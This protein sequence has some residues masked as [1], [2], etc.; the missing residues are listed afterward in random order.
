M[1]YKELMGYKNGIVFTVLFLFVAVNL[2]PQDELLQRGTIPAELL[3]PRREEALRFPIDVVIGPLGQGSAPREAYDIAITA[4]AALLAG[5]A[6]AAVFSSVNKVF[7]EGCMS[8]LNVINPRSYRIGG[9]REEPD[10]SVSFLVRFSGREQGITGELFI[11]QELV[12]QQTPAPVPQ[13]AA[14]PPDED[15]ESAGNDEAEENETSETETETSENENENETTTEAETIPEPP[16][17][18][19]ERRR[20]IFEDLILE[21]PRS[22]AEENALDRMRFDFSPYERLY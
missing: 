9:G 1:F 3:R 17:V 4:A 13:P 12:R 5:N 15:V 16:V 10:G 18:V 14:A 8:A 11:R 19:T 20:W 22:R 2:F 7:I 6:D 21:E